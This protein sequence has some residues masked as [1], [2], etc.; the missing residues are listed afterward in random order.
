MNVFLSVVSHNHSEMIESYGSFMD[1]C[2]EFNVIIKSNTPNDNF[3]FFF[4]K[5]KFTWINNDYNKGFGENNNKIFN[6]C[7]KKLGM[8]DDDYFIVINPDVVIDKRAIRELVSNMLCDDCHFATI[9]LY[10]DSS[11][12]LRD[13]SVRKFPTFLDF[14]A[15]YSGLQNNT[16]IDRSEITSPLFVDWSAGSFLAFKVEHFSKLGGF[17][18][19]YY[20]YCEDIDI[21]MR[22]SNK[23]VP[24]NYYPNI[25]GIHYAKHASKKLFSKNFY[26]HVKSVIRYL[27]IRR[28]Y[29]NCTF[30]NAKVQ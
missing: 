10:K 22:S 17:D 8:Q 19:K 30:N 9:D 25:K 5:D 18:K 28:K 3:S 7:K 2:D 29:A 11:F 21:C 1:L 15:S 26:W 20:M 23:C 24:L 13:P 14:I 6:Y 4:K 16:I 27:I 12:V